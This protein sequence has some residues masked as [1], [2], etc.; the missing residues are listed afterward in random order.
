MCV[1]GEDHVSSFLLSTYVFNGSN[2]TIIPPSVRQLQIHTYIM[3][4]PY[5]IIMCG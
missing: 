1:G 3:P 4:L 5:N 2:I